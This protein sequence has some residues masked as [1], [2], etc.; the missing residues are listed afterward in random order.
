MTLLQQRKLFV[1]RTKYKILKSGKYCFNQYISYFIKKGKVVSI[2][3]PN[4]MTISTNFI[5]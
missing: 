1:F 5:S 3:G 4:K 2:Y